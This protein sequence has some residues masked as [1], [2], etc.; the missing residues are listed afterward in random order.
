MGKANV[1]VSVELDIESTISELQEEDRNS[2]FEKK[3]RILIFLNSLEFEN[4][5]IAASTGCIAGLIYGPAYFGYIET[6]LLGL[7]MGGVVGYI[8]DKVL[9]VN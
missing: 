1:S 6:G 3:S 2:R 7:L 9:P 8:L 5:S 4:I